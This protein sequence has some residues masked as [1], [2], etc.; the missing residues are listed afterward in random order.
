MTG[1]GDHTTSPPAAA[2]NIPQFALRDLHERLDGVLSEGITGI[3]YSLRGY[4]GLAVKEVLLDGLDR[5]SVD[6]IRLE[7]AALPGLSHPGILRYHQVI[8]DEGLIYI[9]TDRHDKTL[10][11]LLTEHRRR[12]SPVSVAVTL[13]LVRQVA[14][15]LA[16][17]RGVSGAG[18]GRPV[19][20]DL[21]PA[22]VL[23]SADG[24]H[25]VIADL[26][27][28]KD[29][30]RSGST[31]A[32][33]RP[34]MAP[35][36]LLRSEASPASDMWSLGVIVYELATLRRPDFLE[37]RE[38][39]EVFVD[40]WRPDLSAVADGFIKDI[41]ERI[42]VLEPE[43]R[44][45]ARELCEMLTVPDIPVS[46]LGHRY[47]VLKYECSSLKAALNS[48]N[49]RIALLEEDAKAKTDRI[50]GLKAAL[51]NR[52][53]EADTLGQEPRI[54]L[55]RIDALEDQVKTLTDKFAQ[56]SGG[57]NARKPQT[58]FFSSRLLRTARTNDTE[59]VRVMLEGG[60]APASATSRG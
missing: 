54:K 36:A 38:P 7:L 26:G 28:C 52:P 42:L 12:K 43:E 53:S 3:V 20:C 27:L 45:T 13:S 44:L 51:E 58:D 55:T 59:A 50:T 2:P 15:A 19:R 30:L 6:A 22:N 5:R 29:A 18:A 23:I 11:R 57:T 48:A 25:F 39:R 8:E 31:L 33:T 41:L 17:L 46:E 56:F 14:A 60:P 16:Y 47:A 35:E 4:P 34:Y 32:G 49:A 37:G 40:G 21:R 24:E 1:S 10:E 9:V